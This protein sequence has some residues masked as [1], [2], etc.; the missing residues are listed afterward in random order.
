M[1]TD[2]VARLINAASR[3]LEELATF[4]KDE[5]KKAIDNFTKE[6]SS[7]L[8]VLEE[9]GKNLLELSKAVIEALGALYR[10]YKGTPREQAIMQGRAG[11]KIADAL[12]GGDAGTIFGDLLGQTKTPPTCGTRGKRWR[13]EE[14]ERALAHY[15]APQWLNQRNQFHTYNAPRAGQYMFGGPG[16]PS[17]AP[18]NNT[19]QLNKSQ[20]ST[21]VAPSGSSFQFNQ[22]ATDRGIPFKSPAPTTP[23]ITKIDRMLQNRNDINRSLPMLI[24]PPGGGMLRLDKQSSLM[25]G[26][27]I[28]DV[29]RDRARM[30]CGPYGRVCAGAYAIGRR[31]GGIQAANEGGFFGACRPA[32]IAVT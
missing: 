12:L 10:Y 3:K 32:D 5:V 2:L 21:V 8:P 6:V 15:R 11:V 27:S 31:A 1:K 30:Y 17:V 16:V 28:F 29:A 24:T 9:L 19:L 7:W 14:H 23:D 13:Y 4:A 18:C 20:G 25:R 26:G 22:G